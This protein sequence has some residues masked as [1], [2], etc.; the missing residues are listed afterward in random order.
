MTR[1]RVVRAD[2]AGN[3]EVRNDGDF[4]LRRQL[5][6]AMDKQ[7]HMRLINLIAW[8]LSFSASI[9]LVMIFT[10]ASRRGL[11]TR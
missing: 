1:R 7:R 8:R 6:D 3:A 4:A 2:S 11:A 5:F 10:D 9:N